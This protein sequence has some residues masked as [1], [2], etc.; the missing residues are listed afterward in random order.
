MDIGND[1][2]DDQG[3]DQADARDMLDA[4]CNKGFGGDQEKAAI[5]L[6]RPVSELREMLDR[7][8]AV[9]D[10][11]EMKMRRIAKERDFRIE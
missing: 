5:V 1:T 11:L 7:Q 3:T 9:D 6:G 8:A 10:D 2:V 4:F